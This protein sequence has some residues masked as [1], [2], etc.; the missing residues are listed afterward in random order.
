MYRKT[1]DKIDN[2]FKYFQINKSEI[3]DPKKQ[4]PEISWWW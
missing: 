2:E 4:A 1:F 3:Q